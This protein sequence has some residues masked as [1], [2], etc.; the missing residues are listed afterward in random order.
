M[1]HYF[2][3][4]NFA[5]VSVLLFFKTLFKDFSLLRY[6]SIVFFL[7]FIWTLSNGCFNNCPQQFQMI[8]AHTFVKFTQSFFYSFINIKLWFEPHG[9]AVFKTSNREI[10]WVFIFFFKVAVAL[11][12]TKN[13]ASIIYIRIHIL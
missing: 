6:E 2:Y 3:N 8:N 10:H 12:S 1:K 5:K 7:L 13:Y 11:F 9:G 4:E